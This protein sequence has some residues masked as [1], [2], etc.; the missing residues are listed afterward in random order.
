MPVTHFL[1]P[2]DTRAEA[3][4]R[5][6]LVVQYLQ[7]EIG[8]QPRL[9]DF[10]EVLSLSVPGN[11]EAVRDLPVPIRLTVKMAGGG[12]YSFE[13]S[14]AVSGLNDAAFV[15][16]A[17]LI[18][19]VSENSRS[20]SSKPTS[21]GEFAS[22]I[23]SAIQDSGRLFGDVDGGQISSL[24]IESPVRNVRP[25][26]GDVVAIRPR[27]NDFRL[28]VVLAHNRFGMA[29][30]FLQGTSRSSLKIPD[31]PKSATL[32]VYTDDHLIRNGTWPIVGHDEGLLTLFSSDPEIYHAPDPIFADVG[33][34]EYGS[35][36]TAAGVLRNLSEREARE[37]GLLDGTYRQIVTSEEIH[38]NPS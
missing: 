22:G 7:D 12:R 17:E 24:S 30:A 2:A 13:R 36:E 23:L 16:T 35:A 18:S 6:R 26:P 5:L 33:I 1:P 8:T 10:L 21:R 4:R 31:R 3:K 37:V 38:R 29:V 28:A 32:P 14:N 27:N 11:S 34:G 25:K 20:D 19:F 9:G 15:E